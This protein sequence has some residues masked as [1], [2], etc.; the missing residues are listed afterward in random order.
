VTTRGGG[1]VADTPE[2]ARALLQTG[3]LVGVVLVAQIVAV[4]HLPVESIPHVLKGR[5]ALCSRVLPYL[6]ASVLTMLGV[7]LF[8]TMVD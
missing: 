1:L 7:G 6:L 5:V 4:R 2:L 8:L 3:V